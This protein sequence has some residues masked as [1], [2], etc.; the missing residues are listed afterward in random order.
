M[1]H[2]FN[3]TQSSETVTNSA[4][5]FLWVSLPLITFVFLGTVFIL[6]TGRAKLPNVFIELAISSYGLFLGMTIPM[7]I[8]NQYNRIRVNKDGLYVR[9]YVFRYVWNFSKSQNEER[10]G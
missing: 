3:T 4:L 1:E 6:I 5:L 2:E 7:Q 9:V 8:I 10:Y